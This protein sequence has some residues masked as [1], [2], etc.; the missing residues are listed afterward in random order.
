MRGP[1]DQLGGTM[2]QLLFVISLL[3]LI[4]T[5]AI[6]EKVA[7]V[8]F[9]PSVSLGDKTLSLNGIGIRKAT[10]FSIKVYVAGLYLEKRSSNPAE[11]V[12]APQAKLLRMEFVRDVNADKIREGWS[13]AFE[14]NAP[15]LAAVSS[16]LTEFNGMMVDMEE[17]DNI[18]LEFRDERVNVSVK[19]EKAGSISGKAF[20]QALLLVWLGKEP[21]N[22]SLKHGLLGV[23]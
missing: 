16:G 11:I 18:V 15:D 22:T 14:K 21:P 6:A 23:E 1:T 19:G 2:K 4:P 13:E 5:H 9:S 3:L 12:A 17:G 7:G 20:Q 8:E 10:I